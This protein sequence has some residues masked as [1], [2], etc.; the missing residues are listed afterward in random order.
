MVKLYEEATR[1]NEIEDFTGCIPLFLNYCVTEYEVDGADRHTA[2]ANAFIIAI[3]SNRE[4]LTYSTIYD[5]N[6]LT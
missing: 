2:F 6:V 3:R 4:L 5:G 1:K